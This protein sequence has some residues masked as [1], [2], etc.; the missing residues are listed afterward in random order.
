MTMANA[1]LWDRTGRILVVIRGRGKE[2]FG[3][4]EI[5]LEGLPDLSLVLNRKYL[6]HLIAKMID[7]LYANPAAVRLREGARHR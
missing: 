7:D 4:S 3:K 6:L 2:N 1:P 5:F